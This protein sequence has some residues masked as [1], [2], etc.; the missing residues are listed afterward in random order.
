MS[1]PDRLRGTSHPADAIDDVNPASFGIDIGRSLR[2]RGVVFPPSARYLAI[3][4]GQAHPEI[5]LAQT[6]GIN[7]SEVTLLDKRFSSKAHN[8]FRTLEFPGRMVEEDVNDFLREPSEAKYDLVSSFGMEYIFGNTTN[9]E[10]LIRGLS[11]KM[12]ENGVVVM[13]P[14]LGNPSLWGGYGF[15]PLEDDYT[16][17]FWRFN[18]PPTEA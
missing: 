2:H 6:L 3:G 8:R 4:A 15:S 17:L 7:F 10:K 16:N 13:F 1:Y 14:P 12:N 18:N 9:L 11:T 5:A